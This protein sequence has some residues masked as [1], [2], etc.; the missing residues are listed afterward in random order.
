MKK[1]VNQL[2]TKSDI[3]VIALLLL[4]SLLWRVSASAT[5]VS[6]SQD[7]ARDVWLTKQRA[8]NNEW[9]VAYGPKTSIGNFFLPPLYNQLHL[10]FAVLTNHQPTTMKWVITI[11]ESLTP[12]VLYL[13][14][15]RIAKPKLAILGSL[16]YLFSVLP[17]VFGTTAW[18]PNLIPL[19]AMATLYGAI[20]IIV[21]KSLRWILVIC[22][23]ASWTM[24]LHFQAA[25]LLTFIFG[26]FLISIGKYRSW[27]TLGYWL[28]GG[29]LAFLFI[30][31]YLW[32]EVNSNWQNTRQMVSFFTTEHTQYYDRISKPAYIITF[33]PKFM[34][35][36]TFGMELYKSL[37]G[38]A[39]YT[40]GFIYMGFKAIKN[41]SLSHALILYYLLSIMMG[42]RLF[43]GDK[44][45]Y[46]LSLLF[47]MASIL[48][49]SAASIFKKTKIGVGLVLIVIF[50]IGFKQSL[51]QPTNDLQ[52]LQISMQMLEQVSPSKS[53][54]L[55]FHDADFV[56]TLFYGL[57]EYTDLSVDQ[58][59]STVVDVCNPR[60]ACRWD[61]SPRS[62]HSPE[63]TLVGDYKLA[64]GYQ[65]L[66]SI[67]SQAMTLWIG[68]VGNPEIP[69]DYSKLREDSSA[70]SDKLLQ[71]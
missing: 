43:K 16:I 42:L 70:G 31:P 66:Y 1:I 21:D 46:Y 53:I 40:F 10:V 36:V 30:S 6:F 9:I 67:S 4:I 25:V 27:R 49:V 18:N 60:K 39:I 14:M 56:N 63:Y 11:L 26:I 32:A 15:R 69:F 33:F 45:D 28:A 5:H 62:Q 38:F 51:W 55:L 41:R 22:V 23:T 7:A 48:F 34:E 47:P 2:N 61:F 58:S 50:I 37:I 44:L 20:K 65:P 52:Q 57:N 68:Q 59:S 13:I 29:L 8:L 71:L 19:L 54:R 3:I 17:S 64:A 12:V 35:R 24:Q